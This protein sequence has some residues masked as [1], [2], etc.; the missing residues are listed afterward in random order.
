[1]TIKSDEKKLNQEM[2]MVFISR[3]IQ[4]SGGTPLKKKDNQMWNK[5]TTE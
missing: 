3:L 4:K 1:M 5:Y 2:M